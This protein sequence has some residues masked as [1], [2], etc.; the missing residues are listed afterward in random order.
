MPSSLPN[1]ASR[2]SLMKSIRFILFSVAAV[3]TANA[4]DWP[5]YGRTNERNMISD[6][7]GLPDSFEVGD[8][9]SPSKNIKW[10]V[11][12]DGE[13]RGMPVAAHGKVYLAAA[14]SASNLKYPLPTRP[15]WKKG[16][17][18]CFDEQTGDLLWQFTSNEEQRGG[19]I[20]Q[21]GLTTA[22]V[23]EKDRLYVFGGRN[24]VFC[25]TTGGL[26]AGNVGP[27]TNEQEFY[28]IQAPY[29]IE[30]N[31]ADMVWQFE[32]KKYWPAIN[33]HNA[34]AYSPLVVGDVIYTS[35]G[36]GAVKDL[37]YMDTNHP[38]RPNADVPTL[39]MLN[40]LTGELIAHDRE[41]MGRGMIHGSWGTPCVGMVNGK[42]QILFG[43]CDGI[44]YGFDPEPEPV[45]GE[46]AK[47]KKIWS[48]DLN[49]HL[50]TY[51]RYETFGPP[52]CVDGKVYAA[53]SDD[54]THPK[55]PGI[56]AC[57]DASGTGDITQSGLV[58]QYRD[59][60]ISL[61][62]VSISKGLVYAADLN[63]RIH[64]LDKDTGEVYWVLK[65]KGDFRANTVVADGKIFIGNSK[66]EF[67]ILK[68]G[69]KLEIL[70]Q[71]RFPQGL[72]GSCIVANGAL[73]VPA[74]D[75]LY[76]IQEPKGK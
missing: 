7:T 76:A 33:Y 25:L 73:F 17:L 58:W 18:Y 32:A 15:D 13:I 66:G 31:D 60:G 1:S 52:V 44:I 71:T 40:K 50:N 39:M 36:N 14:A 65:T 37:E 54:W 8:A 68:E 63:G 41:L 11:R 51:R 12:F 67:F 24:Y 22:P 6:D 75:T 21:F 55:D 23:V 28:K 74:G 56:L 5:Q 48:F 34:Y 26:G 45:T 47:L 2:K 72:S 9:D 64:C 70:H 46:V 49:V 43:G 16:T 20:G 61:G 27:I 38:P 10:K 69:K 19:T 53:V 62:A 35:T 4:A 30:P 57:I 59:I 3:L 42:M 29:S